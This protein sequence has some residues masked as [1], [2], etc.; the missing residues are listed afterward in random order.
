MASAT[1]AEKDAEMKRLAEEAAIRAEEARAEVERV[2]EMRN[3]QRE[4]E[5]TRVAE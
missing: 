5:L 3:H 1:V 4:E 2:L